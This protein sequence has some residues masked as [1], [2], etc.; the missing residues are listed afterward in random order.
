MSDRSLDGAGAGAMADNRF[1][2]L[3]TTLRAIIFQ[4]S[5]QSPELVNA[6]IYAVIEALRALVS[7]EG[8]SLPKLEVVSLTSPLQWVVLEHCRRL[9][10][11]IIVE[12]F[13]SAERYADVA[14]SA[15]QLL[16]N[17]L[18]ADPESKQLH[19]LFALSLRAE[20]LVDAEPEAAR[21]ILNQWQHDWIARD[22]LA[23]QALTDEKN[24]SKSIEESTIWRVA[25]PLRKLVLLGIKVNN[26]RRV[27]QA[28]IRDQ[29]GV[30]RWLRATWQA[31]REYGWPGVQ[32]QLGPL[33]GNRNYQRWMKNYDTLTE[34]DRANAQAEIMAMEAPPTIAVVMPTY[35]SNPEWLLAAIQSVQKQMYP[36]WKLCIA[37]D[38]STDQRVVS[39]LEK[40]AAN[41]SRIEVIF[42][43]D[44]GHIAAATNSALALSDT[45]WVAFLDHDDLL[46][47]HALYEVAKVISQQPDVAL[48][49]SDEDKVDENGKRRDPYFKP[50]WNY[51]LCLSHNLIT[52]LA[53]YRRSVLDEV[54][55]VRAGFDGAQDYDLV[56]RFIEKIQPAQIFHIPRVLYHWRVHQQST[57][58]GADAKPYA[59]LAGQQAINEHFTRR[60]INAYVEPLKF[61]YRPRFALP[62][63]PPKVSIIVPT[64]NA[65]ELVEQCLKSVYTRTI[66]PDFEVILVDNGSNDPA[67]LTAFSSACEQ[68]PTLRYLRDDGAFNFARLCNKGVAEARG[69]II[70]LLN[71]DIEV[72]SP[73]W[74]TELV[75]VACQPDVGA[76]SGKLLYPNGKIQHAGVVL[77]IGGWA[78][79]AHKGFPHDHPGYLG[80][81]ALLSS[82]S[83][84][85]GACMVLQRERF[86]AVNGFDEEAFGVACNDVDLCL[87]LRAKGWMSVYV[88]WAVLY[89]HESAT[90]GYEDTPEKKARF[91]AEV[92]RIWDRWPDIM[93]DDPAYNPNLSLMF[94][95]F[96][97]AWPPRQRV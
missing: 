46:A 14:E 65:H 80:R 12:L 78:G 75:S 1:D 51:P 83:A 62:D 34:T 94:E 36:H 31:S 70:C 52:H 72:D 3:I 79:H 77:G 60:N 43:Q 28:L 5:Q 90:R 50:D 58:G 32:V 17:A 95:D 9:P 29:G 22:P 85:T 23:E 30:L 26:L 89:H 10:N 39:L 38:A 61:G 16:A 96:S 45:A 82:F 19:H 74:L 76:V 8:R 33:G 54:G 44:N 81:A 18:L 88:P 25:T 97:L 42:R 49:Y 91:Q 84:V 7:E 27:I 57:A 93:A 2:S 86:Q 21:S 15:D 24:R 40:A 37:D 35:N 67:A 4:K 64:R 20:L 53:V 71:N 87:R 41:D 48:I 56:L 73:N 68:Y 63:Q 13:P 92:G 11:Q 55:G 66:Y 6:D 47:E 69:A 59:M